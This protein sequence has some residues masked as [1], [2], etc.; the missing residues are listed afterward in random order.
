M[1]QDNCKQKK[2]QP[3]YLPVLSFPHPTALKS[4]WRHAT[5]Y[6]DV[7]HECVTQ[8][9]TWSAVNRQTLKFHSNKL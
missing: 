1:I 8:Q 3:S 9:R 2:N 7:T 4:L 5:I 6:V